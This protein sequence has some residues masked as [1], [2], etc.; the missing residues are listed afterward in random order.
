MTPSKGKRQMDFYLAMGNE[1]MHTEFK[2][3]DH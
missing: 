2:L 3:K 1:D